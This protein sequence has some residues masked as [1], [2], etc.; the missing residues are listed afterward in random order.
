MKKRFFI[1]LIGVLGI[2]WG[3]TQ[4]FSEL[5]SV[6][7]EQLNFSSC[8]WGDFDND[9]DL[10]I[11]I[12]G[13]SMGGNTL[14]YINM[15]DNVFEEVLLA[16]FPNVAHGKIDF[17]EFNGDGNLDIIVTGK[18]SSNTSLTTIYINNNDG[19]FSMQYGTDFGF[20]QFSFFDWGDTDNDGD[21]D[22]MKNGYL[23]L[24]NGTVVFEENKFQEIADLTNGSVEFG[25]Y[26]ADGDKDFIVT[27]DNGW[28]G[29][30][31]AMIYENYGN[32]NFIPRE[33][34]FLEPV[35]YGRAS[36]GDYDNDGDLDI[37]LSG[38]Q[39]SSGFLG[40]YRNDGTDG[41]SPVLTLYDYYNFS[42]WG[43]YDNDGW[44]DFIVSS[45]D[46]TKVFKNISGNSFEEQTNETITGI[47]RG[48]IRFGDYDNDGDL[49]LLITG[50][51]TK[52]YV[53]N[54][55]QANIQPEAPTFL[56][57]VLDSTTAI[58]FWDRGSDENTPTNALFYNVSLIRGIDEEIIS[59]ASFDDGY[60]K[61]V[62]K[63]N[64]DLDTFYVVKD[65]KPGEYKW[66][67]QTIDNG[68]LASSFTQY[69]FFYI[70]DETPILA[71]SPKYPVLSDTATLLSIYIKNIGKGTI[72]YSINQQGDWF[73]L[74]ENSGGDSTV[75]ILSCNVNT[76]AYRKGKIILNPVNP[77]FTPYYI[78]IAQ[79]GSV[80][81]TEV[82]PG[83]FP[84]VIYSSNSWGDY[85][86]DG[87][88]DLILT[89][90]VYN[91]LYIT[92]LFRNNNGNSFE[93]DTNFN[94]IQVNKGYSEWY[95]YNNDG[96]L[97]VIISG[98]LD[99][100]SDQI[101][102]KLYRNIGNST[103]IEESNIELP[104]VA[105]GSTTFGDCN[106]DGKPDLLIMGEDENNLKI[107]DI[108]INKWGVD[109]IKDTCNNFLPVNIGEAKWFD[110]DK[111]GRLDFL[112]RGVGSLNN[113]THLYRN[114]GENI[115][116][117]TDFPYAPG[118]SFVD[119]DNDDNIE[120]FLG[121]SFY[122]SDGSGDF[123]LLKPLYLPRITEHA[124]GDYDND[125]D[126][127]ILFYS[128]VIG[129]LI[130]F[131][132]LGDGTFK[133]AHSVLLDEIRVNS[134]VQFV[135]F[136]ND[137]RLDFFVTGYI[138]TST[139]VSRLYKNNYYLSNQK[140]SPPTVL[141]DSTYADVVFVNWNKGNDDET[142]E[143]GLFYNFYLYKDDGD[144][145]VNSMSDKNTG[146]LRSIS[147]GNANK[148]TNWHI[149]LEEPGTYFW[150]V[151]SIDQGNKGSVF[152]AKEQFSVA[153]FLAFKEVMNNLNW[154]IN[155]SYLIL[156]DEAFLEYVKLDYSIDGGNNWILIN[157][158]ITAGNESYYWTVPTIQP[159]ECLLK[160]SNNQFG[161]S[162]T[163]M[164]NLV[165]QIELTSPLSG[166]EIQ[167]ND[168]LT[169]NWNSIN[170]NYANLEYKIESDLIW[171]LIEDSIPSVESQY[172][173][174]IPNLEPANYSI[175]ISDMEY[176]ASNDSVF[177]SILPYLKLINPSENEEII[178]DLNYVITWESA[179]VDTIAIEYFSVENS[180]IHEVIDDSI[181]ANQFSYTWFVPLNP[182]YLDYKMVVRDINSFAADTS[183][184]FSII[185]SIEEISK[186]DI[187]TIFPN[188]GKKHIKI[189][190]DYLYKNVN[191]K[192]FELQ[193]NIVYH[194]LLNDKLSYD[195]NLVS[196][197]PGTYILMLTVNNKIYRRKIV[198][199]N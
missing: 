156:W 100:Y 53:N 113:N 145:I 95:D 2:T 16:D 13:E 152:A 45:E 64:A 165:P 158:G 36:W 154:Q 199:I 20:G 161:L 98:S 124:W 110:Y 43:D 131:D 29:Y 11:V 133:E 99:Y 26:D 175:R 151:Q 84:G 146:L 77:I 37:L 143:N 137:G 127:D 35:R 48:D 75:V 126:L 44:L 153:E 190:F 176:P 149:E 89:G 129:K 111:D 128:I 51:I 24:N 125:G 163:V 54:S 22:V 10:D 5:T 196:I 198:L 72:Q 8:A 191:L 49:D 138:N 61:I 136:D 150:S 74:S 179:Y 80:I 46:E 33:D 6:D 18:K 15:G 115:F 41:F 56:Q 65:L 102:T 122:R 40:I 81:F 109:F 87:D 17:V 167:T 142:P 148:N 73:Q 135:D 177:I 25:D 170:S 193:G 30:S 52:L 31:Y 34:I 27:G 173:W 178:G 38:N 92:K 103:L 67:V 32:N 157:D 76:G 185:S 104:G 181:P 159:T 130:L 55:N 21:I 106:N 187:F 57:T 108:Y 192:I 164:I 47:D 9:K 141:W 169:I 97:D 189:T 19:T 116:D 160:I 88:L 79:K 119:I 90:K 197:E 184:T 23:Y 120:L 70:G 42:L 118:L 147:K 144:T 121:E 63:G 96:L 134:S 62:K 71:H 83:E 78:E 194:S 117:S 50:G 39:G 4:V 28:S 3:F 168:T 105:W 172:L 171:H 182:F 132:N 155:T 174:G 140:P 58:L 101:Q 66:R 12:T 1:L 86:N 123:E 60:R 186:D 166:T 112:Q 14:L 180:W 114:L 69:D 82:F 59:A 94:V 188:P 68:F 91:N 85:D 107:T 93:V 139:K 7:F 195:I 162:D 183:G